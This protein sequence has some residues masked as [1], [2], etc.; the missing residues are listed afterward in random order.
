VKMFTFTSIQ[1]QSDLAAT[2]AACQVHRHE[3]AAAADVNQMKEKKEKNHFHFL[4]RF[5][6]VFW[7]VRKKIRV[8]GLVWW[9]CPSLR[10]ALLC[11]TRS[12]ADAVACVCNK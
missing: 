3:A 9:V 11:A 2:A 5:L 10:L 6:G 4:C 12:A 7:L 8:A 1:H